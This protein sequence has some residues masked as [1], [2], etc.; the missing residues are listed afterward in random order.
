MKKKNIRLLK[1]KEKFEKNQIR[2]QQM[3]EISKCQNLE[4]KTMT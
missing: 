2:S 3:E 1:M 4:R